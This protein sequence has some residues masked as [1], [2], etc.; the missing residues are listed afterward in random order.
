MLF[1]HCFAK[2][3]TTMIN[4]HRLNYHFQQN[5]NVQ[6]TLMNVDVFAGYA[7]NWYHQAGGTENAKQFYENEK[8]HDIVKKIF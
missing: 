7:E 6:T 5:I 4:V 3:E 1:Q 2:V 8:C